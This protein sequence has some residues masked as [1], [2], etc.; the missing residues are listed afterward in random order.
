MNGNKEM[1]TEKIV[2]EYIEKKLN[3][4]LEERLYLEY[5]IEQCRADLFLPNGC[6]KLHLPP[7]TIIEIKQRLYFDTLYRIK[8][9]YESILVE[10]KYLLLVLYADS[11]EFAPKDIEKLKATNDTRF[12]VESLSDFLKRHIVYRPSPSECFNKGVVTLFLGAGVSHDSGLPGWNDLL[13]GLF[14]KAYP[15]L[16]KDSYNGF[17]NMSG[18][19]SLIT[20]RLIQS[21]FKDN[22]IPDG[23]LHHELYDA[24]KKNPQISEPIITIAE[25]IEKSP[26]IRKV[27]TYNYDD[28]LEQALSEQGVSYHWANSNNE[29]EDSLPICHVHGVLPEDN[30]NVPTK[31]VLSEE[32]Y[33]EMY[34]QAD[35]WANVEQLQSLYRTNCFFIGLSMTD[36]N[37]RRLLEIA[38]NEQKRN[39]NKKS[40]LP[41][42]HF[43]FMEIGEPTKKKCKSY[44][45]AYMDSFEKTMKSL[46]VGVIW[47]EDYGTLPKELKRVAL[48]G[49]RHQ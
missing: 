47:Y 30:S 31:V 40:I 45:K 11:Y 15:Q 1:D 35:C 5:P 36:P 22:K 25:I 12:R 6:E 46:G 37:L 16:C 17:W 9:R 4:K 44:K 18:N 33:H 29:V 32:E 10:D 41:I 38:H 7:N 24:Y 14:A 34:K 13:E 42:R 19:S 3:K 2:R 23:L 27:I 26:N 43:V 39:A 21:A 20:A 28:L 8:N 48:G 49:I